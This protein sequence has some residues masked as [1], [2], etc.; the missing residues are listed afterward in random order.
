LIEIRYLRFGVVGNHV[1]VW[2]TTEGGTGFDVG[3]GVS[4]FASSYID[5]EK[6]TIG[7][8]MGTSQSNNLKLGPFNFGESTDIT[9]VTGINYYYGR[10]WVTGSVGAGISN[11]E[12]TGI[13]GSSRVGHSGALIVW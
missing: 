3:A 11:S 6:P 9:N 8:Y 5:K 4:L 13:G 7:N 12:I 1:F 2:L 10:N